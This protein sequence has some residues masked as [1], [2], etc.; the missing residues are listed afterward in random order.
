MEHVME[1][2]IAREDRNIRELDDAQSWE[3]FDNAAQ[4]YL[5]IS[6]EE[7]IARLETGYY[8]DLDQLDVMSVL[9]LLPFARS[10]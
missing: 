1:R 10:E 8:D 7:F 3:L 5:D 4:H 2:T 9:M 6:G